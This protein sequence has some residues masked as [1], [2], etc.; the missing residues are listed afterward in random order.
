M[1]KLR[2]RMTRLRIFFLSIR[3]KT[4]VTKDH[5]NSVLLNPAV[6]GLRLNQCQMHMENWSQG[7]CSIF[8]VLLGLPE[9]AIFSMDP[10][11]ALDALFI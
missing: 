6:I 11:E 5:T 3:I 1:K 8:A 7:L 2:P 10:F 9:G 4:C